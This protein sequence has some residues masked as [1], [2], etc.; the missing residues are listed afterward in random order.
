MTFPAIKF[1]VDLNDDTDF[2]DS[3][4]DQSALVKAFSFD[5]GRSSTL[6]KIRPRRGTVTL[7]NADGRFSP[8]NSGSALYPNFTQGKLAKLQAR[9]TVGSLSVLNDN[10][11]FETDVNGV[12]ATNATVA[13]DTTEAR[14]GKASCKATWSADAITDVKIVMRSGA[15]IPAAALTNHTFAVKLKS[16]SNASFR[17][18]ISWYDGSGVFISAVEST[19]F[20]L[21][22]F[23]AEYSVDGISPAGTASAELHIVESAA[24]TSG[25]TLFIDGVNFYSGG[26]GA[27]YCDGDQPGCVWA[28]TAHQSLSSRAANPTFDLVTGYITSIDVLRQSMAGRCEVEIM[29]RFDFLLDEYI[30]IGNMI[31]EPIANVINRVLDILEDEL[32]VDPSIERLTPFVNYSVLGSALALIQV[33]Y[34]ASDDAGAIVEGDFAGYYSVTGV[35]AAGTGWRYTATADTANSTSYRVGIFVRAAPLDTPKSMTLRFVSNLGTTESISFSANTTPQYIELEGS[36]AAGATARYIELVQNGAGVSGIGAYW[37]CFHLQK[38]SKHIERDIQGTTATLKHV[39]AYRR[40][41]RSLLNEIADS[42]G[43]IFWEKGNGT[44]VF[45]DYLTRSTTPVPAIRFTDSA[46]YDGLFLSER[47]KY[48]EQLDHSYTSVEIVSDGNLTGGGIT[49]DIIS[50]WTLQP[51]QSLGNNES[52]TYFINYLADEG[53]PLIG[54][55]PGGLVLG[56]PDRIKPIAILTAGSTTEVLDNYGV[57]ATLVMTAGASGAT[58]TSLSITGRPALR[59]SERSR[60]SY[61]PA[62]AASRLFKRNLQL[63]MPMQGDRTSL[64]TT[65]AQRIGDKFL[66]G[67]QALKA[68]LFAG[69]TEQQLAALGSDLSDPV[70]LRHNS[71]TAFLG[72]NEA[73]YIEGIS[74]AETENGASGKYDLNAIFT[75]ERAA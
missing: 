54:R 69:T 61:T 20:G 16:A 58:F 6:E 8:K 22:N 53:N 49:T 13:Q 68:N 26:A 70:W 41:A 29:S 18:R 40:S 66:S 51:V 36:W 24:F 74:I 56:E 15:R 33:D 50:L 37:D 60:V 71:G 52:R 65:M 63:D 11:S 5:T 21:T 14:H 43:G 39:A 42:A 12:T 45:E 38:L 44:V 19:I 73:Y 10:P 28:G 35:G 3:N 27:E 46:D 1:L 4:E 23:W 55:S 7:D 31:D 2:A 25:E 32:I 30:S 75:L 48:S 62:G 64:M 17:V 57:G 67:A 47:L 59:Q 72:L 9:V 34:S